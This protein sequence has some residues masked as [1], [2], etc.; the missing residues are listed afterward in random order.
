VFYFS[1]FSYDDKD[2]GIN[3]L[4][5]PNT[6]NFDPP[7][8]AESESG[9]LFTGLDVEERAKLIKELPL[10]DYFLILKGEEVQ[11]YRHLIIERLKKTEGV[12]RIQNIDVADLPSKSNLVF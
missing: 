2:F 9:G 10:T 7:L 8:A 11:K 1:L 6:S 12:L 5:V 4:F 3:Y